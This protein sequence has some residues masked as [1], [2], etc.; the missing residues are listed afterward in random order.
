MF[1]IGDKVFDEVDDLGQGEVIDI[2]IN[3]HDNSNGVTMFVV[4]FGDDQVFD[5]LEHELS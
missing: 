4:E 5:R 2:Y 1:N 3:Y